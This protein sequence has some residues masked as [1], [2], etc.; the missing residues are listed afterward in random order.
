MRIN[1]IP[2]VMDCRICSSLEKSSSYTISNR[3]EVFMKLLIFPMNSFE[4]NTSVLFIDWF[5]LVNVSAVE[6]ITILDAIFC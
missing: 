4:K 5:K 1:E 2:T 6:L 3:S